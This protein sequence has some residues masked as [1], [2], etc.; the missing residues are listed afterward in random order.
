MMLKEVK[1]Y[2]TDP[3]VWWFKIDEAYIEEWTIDGPQCTIWR[4]DNDEWRKQ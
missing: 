3:R 2:Q 4:F 1:I